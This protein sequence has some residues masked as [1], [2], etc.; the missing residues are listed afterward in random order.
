MSWEERIRNI[1]TSNKQK[2][3]ELEEQKQQG[4]KDIETV[5]SRFGETFEKIASL[6][7]CRLEKSDSTSCYFWWRM[8]LP[9][10]VYYYNW[11]KIT[12]GKDEISLGRS[13]HASIG[14]VEHYWE[15]VKLVGNNDEFLKQ[16]IAEAVEKIL[17]MGP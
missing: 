17:K 16:K 13:D 5:K 15:K 14:S 7:G 2:A 11:L 1:G 4:I 10:S 9:P 3:Q 6:L 8:E 12:F